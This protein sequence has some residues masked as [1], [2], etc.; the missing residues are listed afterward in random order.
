MCKIVYVLYKFF[1]NILVFLLQVFIL[2]RQPIISNRKS[3]FEVKMWLGNEPSY[4]IA[5][6]NIFLISISVS[7]KYK[8]YI[9][10]MAYAF[11]TIFSYHI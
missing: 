1:I 11:E 10:I 5:F 4:K 2:T 8:N 3:W 9:D 7:H 6:L